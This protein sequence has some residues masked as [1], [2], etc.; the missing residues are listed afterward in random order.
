MLD[1][2]TTTEGFIK[3]LVKWQ[4]LLHFENSWESSTGLQQEFP[5]TCYPGGQDEGFGGEVLLG[6]THH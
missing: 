2:K 6:T 4:S 1:Y 5:T 3:A